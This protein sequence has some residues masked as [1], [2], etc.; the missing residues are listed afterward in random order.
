M[1]HETLGLQYFSYLQWHCYA[2][3]NNTISTSPAAATFMPALF[4]KFPHQMTLAQA[5]H[6]IILRPFKGT[7]LTIY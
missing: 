2:S 5:R 1:V 6:A 3:L 7:V 4:D